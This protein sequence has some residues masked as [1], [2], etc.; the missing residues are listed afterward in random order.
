MFGKNLWYTL[1]DLNK[2]SGK[3]SHRFIHSVESFFLGTKLG[4]ISKRNIFNILFAY[5][6]IVVGQH[7]APLLLNK[8]CTHPLTL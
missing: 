5:K 1:T 3:N 4:K 7:M 8:W 2:V 6:T